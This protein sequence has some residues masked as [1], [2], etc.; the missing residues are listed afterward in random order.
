MVKASFSDSQ[1]SPIASEF[2]KGVNFR[3]TLGLL[4]T[5]RER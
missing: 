5:G 1:D 4:S 2:G 3:R